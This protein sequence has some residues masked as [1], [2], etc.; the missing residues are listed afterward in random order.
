MIGPTRHNLVGPISYVS[1][2]I[3][4][5]MRKYQPAWEKLKKDKKI[6]IAA[7]RHLHARILKA[8]I[9]EKDSYTLYKLD[10]LED[11]RRARIAHKNESNVLTILLTFSTGESDWK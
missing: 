8:I 4:K 10:L 11:S 1:I 6:V 5:L 3:N 9:K 7:H 2:P